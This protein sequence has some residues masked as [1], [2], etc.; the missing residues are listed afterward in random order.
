[1]STALG[2]YER[3]RCLFDFAQTVFGFRLAVK[4][5]SAASVPPIAARASGK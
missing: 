4:R 2:R 5:R 1:M 3:M